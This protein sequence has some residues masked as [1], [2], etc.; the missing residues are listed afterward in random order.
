ML[1][2]DAPM[3]DKAV[4]ETV[5]IAA[6]QSDQVRMEQALT[7]TGSGL[8]TMRITLSNALDVPAPVE[9]TLP[10]FG[11]YQIVSKAKLVAKGREKMLTL[12]LPANSSR[13]I[14]ITYRQQ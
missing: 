4:G 6:G 3:A 2:G 5:E 13:A 9:I 7:V 12:I 14:E 10:E 1:L 8:R 11:S